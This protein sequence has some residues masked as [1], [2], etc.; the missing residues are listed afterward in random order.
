MTE[1]ILECLAALH[2]DACM[3]DTVSWRQVLLKREIGASEDLLS[4]WQ[5]EIPKDLL[6]NF[7]INIR[8][9]ETELS[10]CTSRHRSP[11]HDRLG[12]LDTWFDAAWLILLSW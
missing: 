4:C 3:S 9:Q 7:G 5:H 11:D 2:T 1:I 8:L 12:K 10:N 6:V